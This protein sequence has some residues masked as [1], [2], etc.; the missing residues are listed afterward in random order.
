M[1]TIVVLAYTESTR[2]ERQIE[3]NTEET[4]FNEQASPN[5]SGFP[6]LYSL[7][8]LYIVSEDTTPGRDFIEPE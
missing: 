3:K 2:S 8:L 7:F 6:V 5:N 1:W 4:N